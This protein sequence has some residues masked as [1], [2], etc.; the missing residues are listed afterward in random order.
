[1]I[2]IPGILNHSNPIKIIDEI[3][4][5][6]WGTVIKKSSPL[7]GIKAFIKHNGDG[8]SI[9]FQYN[10]F[11]PIQRKLSLGKSYK[12]VKFLEKGHSIIFEDFFLYHRSTSKFK[13]EVKNLYSLGFSK[14]KNYRYQLIIPLEREIRLAYTIEE[15]LFTSDLGFHSRTSTQAT[16]NNDAISACIIEGNE[17]EFYLAIESKTLQT[18]DDFSKKAHA[19]IYGLGYLSGYMAG[20][21]GYY[22]AYLNEKLKRPNHFYSCALRNSM[23]STLRPACSNPYSYLSQKRPIAEKILKRKILRTVKITEFSKLCQ[24]LHDSQEFE[25][26]VLLILESNVASLLFRPGGYAIALENLSNLIIAGKKLDLAPIKNKKL[27]TRVVKECQNIITK[28]CSATIKKE[29]L[30]LLLSRISSNLNKPT[31]KSQLKAP[32]DILKIRLLE[33]DMKILDAR[34]DFLHGRFPDFTNEGKPRSLDRINKDLLYASYR[35][36]TLLNMLILKWI[37]YDNRVVNY[38]KLNEKYCNIRLKEEYFRSV[39]FQ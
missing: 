1:M 2:E 29:P 28:Y 34:N 12:K 10:I 9:E 39:Y 14:K 15:T 6:K 30:N 33:K 19:V 3:N 38:P 18:F 36:Y 26:A 32:F 20:N 31:N 22:F 21:K 17:K 8:F 13:A 4:K 24:I 23:E 16:I 7:D 11:S 37:G 27:R 25:A 35:L 5:T